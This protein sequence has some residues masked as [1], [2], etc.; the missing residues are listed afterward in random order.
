VTFRDRLQDDVIA[1]GGDYRGDLT[2]NVAHL[3]ALAP[4]GKKYQYASR[5][6]IEFLSTHP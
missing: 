1:H 6:Q 3:I 2:K 4:E 5:L